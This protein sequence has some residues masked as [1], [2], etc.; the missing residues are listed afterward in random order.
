M[1]LLIDVEKGSELEQEFSSCLMEWHEKYIKQ[2]HYLIK[3]IHIAAWNRYFELFKF[4][5]FKVKNPNEPQP[6][7]W[8]PIHLAAENGHTEIF[9]LL[10]PKVKNPNAPMPV[11]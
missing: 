8:T 4:I 10:V 3:P 9:K 1:E 11:G 7:G 6:I 2:K 5:A